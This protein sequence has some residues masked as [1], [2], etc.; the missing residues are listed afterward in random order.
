MIAV[1]ELLRWHFADRKILL[2]VSGGVDS[3]VLLFLLLQ[4]LSD[5][6]L[7]LV[8]FDHGQRDDTKVDQDVIRSLLWG[9]N[10]ELHVVN[11]DLEHEYAFR[12][13]RVSV[14]YWNLLQSS[15]VS[16]SVSDVS[17]V[18]AAWMRDKVSGFQALASNFRHNYLMHLA[19]SL[20][21]DCVLTAHHSDDMNESCLR[22]LIRGGYKSVMPMDFVNKFNLDGN[23]IEFVKPLLSL[24]KT[25]IYELSR[26]Y[27]IGF[28]TDSSNWSLNYERNRIR[29]LWVAQSPDLFESLFRSLRTDA[30]INAKHL[31]DIDLDIVSQVRGCFLTL[32]ISSWE[33]LDWES[34]VLVFRNLFGVFRLKVL[35]EFERFISESQGSSEFSFNN[36]RVFK[37]KSQLFATC[38][39]DQ[40]LR[41]MLFEDC[42][43]FALKDM[44][45]VY[46]AQNISYK[47]L[48]RKLNIPVFLRSLTP[49][50]KLNGSLAGEECYKLYSKSLIM[51]VYKNFIDVA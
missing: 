9:R 47:K 15:E 48:F 22:S 7:H 44:N 33:C 17:N 26:E 41:K 5:E 25:Q 2:A 46:D 35:V 13:R 40:E 23:V 18:S 50:I 6:Q 4:F 45:F 37:V 30:Y 16:R 10:I 3:Q 36:I 20:G 51:S 38:F 31:E 21:V 1:K 11:V 49:V 42:D 34:R 8:Y 43:L 27:L 14:G 29:N 19:S 12:S 24:K 32:S 28:N 39:G